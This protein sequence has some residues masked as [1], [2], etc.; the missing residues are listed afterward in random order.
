LYEALALLPDEF[1]C[2]GEIYRGEKFF[3]VNVDK[4]DKPLDKG[5]TIL[6]GFTSFTTDKNVAAEF[7]LTPA[8]DA[9]ADPGT[10][11]ID[12]SQDF[13]LK[14]RI[15]QFCANFAC[16]THKDGWVT[17]VQNGLPVCDALA[18][19]YGDNVPQLN[20]ELEKRFGRP[21]PATGEKS[22]RNVIVVEKGVG[23]DI[24]AFSR[25]PKES[26]VMMEAGTQLEVLTNSV[27]VW[28]SYGEKE[29]SNRQMLKT[30][31]YRIHS[32]L[33]QRNGIPFVSEVRR[34]ADNIIEHNRLKD[35]IWL[36]IESCDD[37]RGAEIREKM[38]PRDVEMFA[39]IVHSATGRRENVS[40]GA[41]RSEAHTLAHVQTGQKERVK[42]CLEDLHDFVGASG[43]LV[44]VTVEVSKARCDE[45]GERLAAT[46]HDSDERRYRVEVGKWIKVTITNWSTE[47]LTFV[48]VYMGDDGEDPF[49]EVSLASGKGEKLVPLKKEAGVEEWNFKDFSGGTVLKLKFEVWVSGQPQP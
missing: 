4:D 46:S 6:F 13:T 3:R 29:D 42:T 21:L 8:L 37:E 5:D 27:R 1:V 47:D 26:E 35:K 7:K 48:P 45:V 16:K 32:L 20:K 9:A 30:R 18:S 36:Y 39:T 49:A 25:F 10:K 23:Y 28:E 34:R 24:A 15:R 40:R 14:E 41:L 31:M 17:K 33:T 38:D 12:A 2:R 11:L 22:Q 19:R 44:Q 43:W